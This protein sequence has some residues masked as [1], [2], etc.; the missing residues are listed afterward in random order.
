[1]YKKWFKTYVCY[2]GCSKKYQVKKDK[3]RIVTKEICPK[4]GFYKWCFKSEGRWF[5]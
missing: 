1:M 2:C 4:C 5:V 3:N